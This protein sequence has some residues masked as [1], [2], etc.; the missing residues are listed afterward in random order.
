MGDEEGIQQHVQALT[1]FLRLA[2]SGFPALADVRTALMQLE[3]THQIFAVDPAYLWRWSTDAAD[4][5][6]LL[7][8]HVYNRH[9]SQH[10]SS[11]QVA[12]LVDLINPGCVPPAASSPR[13]DAPGFAPPAASSPGPDAPHAIVAA[14]QH[15]ALTATEINGM[16]PR[17]QRSPVDPESEGDEPPE[18][19]SSGSEGEVEI[20][21]EVLITGTRC[22]CSTCVPPAPA[23]FVAS[24]CRIPAA[25][26]GG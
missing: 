26:S 13:T 25:K 9:R 24:A 14:G 18:E 7:C 23:A 1:P 5:W 2:P 15:Q 8:R 20:V 16:F 22:M 4:Q 12:A 10:V 3:Q 17:W 21:D 11:P 19:P 6:R